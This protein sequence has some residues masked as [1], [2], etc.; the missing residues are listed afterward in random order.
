MRPNWTDTP[1]TRTAFDRSLFRLFA[2]W[3]L[4]GT[5]AI[6]FQ[7]ATA[8][9]SAIAVPRPDSASRL[10]GHIAN[11]LAQ[12]NPDPILRTR[13]ARAI[14]REANNTHL[15]A[16]LL[17]GVLLVENPELKP[18]ARNPRSGALGLMQVMPFHAGEYKCGSKNLR[19]IESNICHGSHILADLIQESKGSHHT[20]LLHYNGCR[21]GSV[22]PNCFAYPSAVSRN[23]QKSRRFITHQY[24]MAVETG[25]W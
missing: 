13:I 24:A 7:P 23:A 22:T 4:M 18:H 15:D 8:S 16:S 12:Y 20:A 6:R 1:L 10:A 14:V 19:Q 21:T 17:V 5:M 2:V 11:F 3:L 9:P 25:A